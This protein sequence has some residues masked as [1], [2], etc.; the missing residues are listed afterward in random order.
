MFFIFLFV[1]LMTFLIDLVEYVPMPAV[2]P[3]G[4]YGVRFLVGA[5][6]GVHSYSDSEP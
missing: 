3:G 2:T 5:D 1:F 4:D 6:D